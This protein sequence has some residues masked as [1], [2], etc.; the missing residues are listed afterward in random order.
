MAAGPEVL[1]VKPQLD[2]PQG[3]VTPVA[4]ISDSRDIIYLPPTDGIE[5]VR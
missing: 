5:S 4:P 3:G 2:T 1:F